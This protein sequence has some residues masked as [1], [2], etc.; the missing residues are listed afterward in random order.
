MYTCK[1]FHCLIG[2]AVDGLLDGPDKAALEQHLTECAACRRKLADMTAIR[3]ELMQPVEAPEHLHST[4]MAGIAAHER[5]RRLRNTVKKIG[6][7]AAAL[8]I[9]FAVLGGLS[10]LGAGFMNK[11]ANEAA[12]EPSTP[13]T[14]MAPMAAPDLYSAVQEANNAAKAPSAPSTPSTAVPAPTAPA[15]CPAEPAAPSDVTDSLF[16]RLM[17]G[18]GIAFAGVYAFNLFA[19]GDAEEIR[20][21]LDAALAKETVEGYTV[22][23]V[24]ADLEAVL[25]QLEGIPVTQD[26]RNGMTTEGEAPRTG[27]VCVKNK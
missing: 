21:K 15:P 23:E 18:E 26:A 8:V 4:I 3:S 11:S 25:R 10:M 12:A 16:N 7:A 6:S 24:P 1:D 22:L 2:L 20:K 9:C 5:R 27:L 17:D 14:P 13:S 19:E